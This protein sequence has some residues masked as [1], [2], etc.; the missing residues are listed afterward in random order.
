MS[1]ARVTDHSVFVDFD[2][3]G[4][5]SLK[6]LLVID[7]LQKPGLAHRMSARSRPRGAC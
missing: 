7:S 6:N 5:S 3:H 4:F 2:K 1:H